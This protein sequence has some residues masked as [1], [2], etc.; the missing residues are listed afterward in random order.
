MLTYWKLWKSI[1]ICTASCKIKMQ[2]ISSSNILFA[3]ICL[4]FIGYT[5]PAAVLGAAWPMM[6]ESLGVSMSMQS[7]LSYTQNATW[8]IAGIVGGFLM[9]RCKIGPVLFTC[10]IIVSAALLG[11][12]MSGNFWILFLLTIPLGFFIGMT[13]M[14]VN[15]FATNNYKP[16]QFTWLHSIASFGSMLGPLVIAYFLSGG[17]Q[18]GYRAVAVIQ[19]CIGAIVLAVMPLWS[20]VGQSKTGKEEAESEVQV[21]TYRQTL[22]HRGVIALLL[23]WVCH[24]GMDQT[25]GLWGPTF[26]VFCR[27]LSEATA[28]TMISVYFLGAVLGRVLSGVLL[29]WMTSRSLIIGGSGVCLLGVLML[30]VFRAEILLYLGFALIGAGS[31]PIFPVLAAEVPHIFG[32]KYTSPIFG[33]QIALSL[34]NA[35][36]PALFGVIADYSLSSFLWYTALFALL[37][38]TCAVTM[39]YRTGFIEKKHALAK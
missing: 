35:A 11:F 38:L 37:S 9:R 29:R 12:S 27:D 22:R 1:W 17:W 16:S 10:M 31:G 20:K 2:K 13:D 8:S 25:V 21:A 18:N 26:V 14:Y 30:T 32:K 36:V 39:Y 23:T 4:I 24:C 34:L 5:L 3:A 7:I 19:L 6:Y 33:T 15:C 28:A